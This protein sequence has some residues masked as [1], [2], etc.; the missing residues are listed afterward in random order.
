MTSS[1]SP[2]ALR[3]FARRLLALVAGRRRDP[4]HQEVVPLRGRY[5]MIVNRQPQQ[6]SVALIAS[7]GAVRF[8][9]VITDNGPEITVEAQTL[10]LRTSGTLAIDAE[11]IQLHGRE[12]VAVTTGGGIQIEANQNVRINGERIYLNS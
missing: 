9:I 11:R 8:R 7:D 12:A 4:P 10:S 1:S 5:Q 6:D 3:S 2:L